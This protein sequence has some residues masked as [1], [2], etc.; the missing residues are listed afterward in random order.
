M[1]HRKLQVFDHYQYGPRSLLTPG[2]RFRVS[3]GPVYV[4]AGGENIPW[5]I[6]VSL[7]SDVTAS[8]GQRSGSR[9]TA[10]TVA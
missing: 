7:S 8:K 10:L 5:E 3:G 4:T 6:A 1:S 9:P 2:D